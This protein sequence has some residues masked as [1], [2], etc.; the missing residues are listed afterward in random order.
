MFPVSW[1]TGIRMDYFSQEPPADYLAHAVCYLNYGS[2]TKPQFWKLVYGQQTTLSRRISTLRWQEH[3]LNIILATYAQSID[4]F[5][6]KVVP[7]THCTRITWILFLGLQTTKMLLEGKIT[8]PKENVTGYFTYEFSPAG[9]RNI[10]WRCYACPENCKLFPCLQMFW[11]IEQM[12]GFWSIAL[13][14]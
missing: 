6:L 4:S 12:K 9:K 13:E 3:D 5:C 14:H 10:N 2:F 8:R 11:Q 7:N 1:M